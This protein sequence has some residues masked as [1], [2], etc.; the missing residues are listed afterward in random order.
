MTDFVWQWNVFFA[1]VLALLAITLVL[2]GILTAYFGSGKSRAVG[3]V[4]LIV[5]LVIGLITI[6]TKSYIGLSSGILES[7]IV[8]TFFYVIASVVGLA[9]GLLV[10]LGAIMKT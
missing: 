3:V 4:L 7:V 5:G 9:I 8:P 10:F 1:V 6:F 2:L